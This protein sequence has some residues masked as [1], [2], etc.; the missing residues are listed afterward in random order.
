MCVWVYVCLCVCVFVHVKRST[1][2]IKCTTLN[3]ISSKYTYR[4]YT[5]KA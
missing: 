5:V 1:L 3:K 4:K 2:Y